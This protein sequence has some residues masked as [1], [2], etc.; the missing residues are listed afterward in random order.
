VLAAAVAG[1]QKDDDVRH[2]TAPKVESPLPPV[3]AVR[4]TRLL[5]AIVPRGD[6]LWVVKVMGP[7]TAI[8]GL[9]GEFEAFLDSVSFKDGAKSPT[10]KV[11][12]S[13]RPSKGTRFSVAAYRIGPDEEAPELT[14]TPSRG[15]VEDNVNRWRGQVGLKPFAADEVKRTTREKKI[16]NGTAVV[17]DLAGTASGDG[18]G[19]PPFAGQDHRTI[20]EAAPAVAAEPAPA[21]APRLKYSLPPGWREGGEL[22]KAGI[23]RVAVFQVRDSAGSAEVS[24]T[25]AGGGVKA[26]VDRWRQQVGL[27]ALSD[28]QFAREVTTLMVAGGPAVYVDLSGDGKPGRQGILGAVLPRGGESWF[29]KMTGTA[30]VVG[31]QKGAFEAFLKSV[32]FEGGADE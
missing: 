29:F 31:R 6:E 25:K 1:C 10:F 17:V 26:N 8:N 12:D 13:W 4:A 5:G 32:R 3:K 9:E 24:V 16:G 15:S 22:V 14:V 11:P 19:R 7:E 27:Q 2:Y 18:M 21:A 20:P 30:D 28:E 23:R